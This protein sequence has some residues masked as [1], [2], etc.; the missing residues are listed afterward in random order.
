MS[1][2]KEKIIFIISF[3]SL[4]VG[5][6]STESVKATTVQN[7][8]NNVSV[9]QYLNNTSSFKKVNSDEVDSFFDK[10]DN[11]DRYLYI[12]RPTCYYCRQYSATL[13]EF[14]NL[15]G[16]QLYYL[17]IDESKDNADYAFD[18]LEVP[19]TPTVMRIKNGE[20]ANAWV[21]GG[22]TATELYDFLKNQ[23]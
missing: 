12:G 5:L 15:I 11:I 4:I 10:K 22:K 14:N 7:F 17:N 16:G 6:T 2:L 9:N 20:I 21:G 19:G 23:G 3:I 13:N 8:E 18:N 1:R